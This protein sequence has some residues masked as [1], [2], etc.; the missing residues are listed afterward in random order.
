[1]KFT[2]FKNKIND[3]F[4]KI[5]GWFFEVFVPEEANQFFPRGLQSKYLFLYGVIL[6]GIKI[7][8]ISFFLILPQFDYFS[9][10]TQQRLLDLI[11]RARAENG[12]SQVVL[13]TQLSETASFK[14]EDMFRVGYFDHTSPTGVTPW[15]W[16]KKAGYNYE[17][18]GEN[19]AI[20]FFQSDDVFNAWM[21]SPAHRE[22]ILN[23]NFNEI[24][25]AVKSDKLQNQETVL[26]VLVFGKQPKKN[27]QVIAD[28][29]K[30][31]QTQ[32]SSLPKNQQSKARVA[33][34]NATPIIQKTIPSSSL[35]PS[36]APALAPTP[37]FQVL[38]AEN[39]AQKNLLENIEL[40]QGEIKEPEVSPSSQ[41]AKM[42][43]VDNSA[44]EKTSRVLGA[45]VS[46]T[47]EAVK[48]FYLY[49]TLFLTLALL[50]NI[51]VKIEV[52]HW[53]TIFSAI[54]IIFISCLLVFI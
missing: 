17:Y 31:A 9:T 41:F 6:I 49:F 16:F 29:T 2:D 28:K 34:A 18:A 12:L 43:K 44:D 38:P 26:A 21:Q 3:F 42:V 27:T 35:S 54:F 24:G 20:N 19:L 22:N 46:K 7:G 47:D 11:N 53:S 23:A 50:V 37:A 36:V 1:M 52:Q 13:N 39:P 8:I 25:L 10:I 14:I 30:I 15:F 51:F 4:P 45:F 48:S 33:T 32:P 5:R 40:K